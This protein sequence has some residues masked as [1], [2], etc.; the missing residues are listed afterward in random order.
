MIATE[1]FFDEKQN[2]N[3]WLNK[4]RDDKKN[5]EDYVHDQLFKRLGIRVGEV[6]AGILLCKLKYVTKLLKK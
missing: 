5:G 6:R 2:E 1:V 3:D 4:I